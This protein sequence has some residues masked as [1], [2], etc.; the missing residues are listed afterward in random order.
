MLS[1]GDRT[2]VGCQTPSVMTEMQGSKDTAPV[3]GPRQARSG[4]TQRDAV[5]LPTAHRS[6][7]AGA[8]RENASEL[9]AGTRMSAGRLPVPTGYPSLRSFPQPLAGGR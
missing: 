7:S 2:T 3:T 8:R 4:I 1:D 9:F 5:P 6:R